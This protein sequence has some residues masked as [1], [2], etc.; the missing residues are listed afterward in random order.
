MRPAAQVPDHV[1]VAVSE[2]ATRFVPVSSATHAAKSTA[3]CSETAAVPTTVRY[4]GAGRQQS[5]SPRSPDAV[6]GA[7]RAA[8]PVARPDTPREKCD[9]GSS[10]GFVTQ[11]TVNGPIVRVRRHSLPH[12]PSDSP[13]RGADETVARLNSPYRPR[14]QPAEPVPKA[15]EGAPTAHVQAVPI[16]SLSETKKLALA[17]VADSQNARPQ[18]RALLRAEHAREDGRLF[19]SSSDVVLEDLARGHSSVARLPHNDV[20]IPSFQRSREKATARSGTERGSRSTSPHFGVAPPSA[21]AS[22]SEAE[23]GLGNVSVCTGSP[24]SSPV[25]G[26]GQNVRWTALKK[27]MAQ[28]GSEK[29]ASLTLRRVLALVNVIN[30]EAA[31]RVARH[32]NLRLAIC[33]ES[34]RIFSIQDAF[35]Q[36]MLDA[37]ESMKGLQQET[38]SLKQEVNSLRISMFSALSDNQA[39][40]RQDFQTLASEAANVVADTAAVFGTRGQD[41]EKT[42]AAIYQDLRK[43]MLAESA[44]RQRV[45][46]ATNELGFDIERESILRAKGD[47]KLQHKINGLVDGVERFKRRSADIAQKLASWMTY[48]KTSESQLLQEL[49]VQAEKLRALSH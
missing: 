38:L 7:P 42:R 37:R 49:R 16:A 24:L 23:R 27:R 34:E 20:C 4:V 17:P 39:E 48:E 43:C 3:H 22:S 44:E 29:G 11:R 19:N 14:D 28:A 30:R 25:P 36:L 45:C 13:E 35:Q 10:A 2:N 18:T 46:I 32:S 31:E 6:H 47:A 1:R 8:T 26:G 5:S 12:T 40:A 15:R 9:C 21:S 41:V 33:D